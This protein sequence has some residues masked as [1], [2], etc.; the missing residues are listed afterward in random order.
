[1]RLSNTWNEINHMSSLQKRTFQNIDHFPC[2]HDIFFCL[3]E[4][5]TVEEEEEDDTFDMNIKV[6]DPEKIGVFAFALIIKM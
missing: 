1:M 4:K 2:I 5:E 3:Q 6:T